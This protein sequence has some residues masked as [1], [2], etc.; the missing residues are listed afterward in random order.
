MMTARKING[1]RQSYRKVF[2]KILI[3]SP[4]LGQ[5]KSAKNDP[6]KDVPGEQKWKTFTIAHMD[7]IFKTIESNRDDDEQT[8]L[9]LD[10]IGAQLRKSAHAEKQLVTLL[11]NRRH[12]FCSVFILVQRYK[13]LPSGI[14][15]NMS[16]FVS[17]RPKN[18]LE[19]MSICDEVF[20]FHRRQHQ[21]IMDYVFDNADR[22]SFLLIDMSLKETNKFRY[23]NKFNEILITEK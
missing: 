4:T 23:F 1:V 7:E 15:N 8:V 14:R 17:F 9:I 13:D 2:N 11:Q 22:F 20:P 3:C 19:H 18:Q 12:L 5:G 6:F 21:K 10:D 16:H